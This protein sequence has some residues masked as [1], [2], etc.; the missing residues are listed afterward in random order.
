MVSAGS[1]TAVD[2]TYTP[3][4]GGLHGGIYQDTVA[5]V[6]EAR[7]AYGN[8]VVRGPVAE[9]QV[10]ETVGGDA[11]VGRLG[12]FITVGYKGSLVRVSAQAGVADME[13]ALQ[14]LPT[15]GQ[16]TVST[17]SCRVNSGLQ[18]AVTQGN[19]LVTASALGTYAV[20]DWIRLADPVTGPVFTVLS[21]DPAHN[22]ILLSSPYFGP[23][24][25][26]ALYSQ[27][28]DGYQYIV[29]FD[30]NLGDLPAL[31]VT[32]DSL[33]EN[34]NVT[35]HAYV[36]ACDQYT[37]QLITTSASASSP[38]HLNGTFSLSMGGESTPDL[39]YDVSPTALASAL[40]AF[41]AVYAVTVT[42]SVS[43]S[44]GGAA[45][46]GYAW[47]VTYVATDV[48]PS[49]IV[50][51]GHLLRGVGARITVDAGYCPSTAQPGAGAVGQV[52]PACH[53]LHTLTHSHSHTHTHIFMQ[54]LTG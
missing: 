14:S 47:T 5:F 22:T 31:T 41:D 24:G 19:A 52:R 21:L 1:T 28:R 43:N 11:A 20:G 26:V 53:S 3:G 45:V 7:D 42:R 36:T 35:S 10:I 48:A 12:G 13:R 50:A 49:A 23:T 29:T 8:R 40:Q 18:G 32:S 39:P 37:T 6:I 30:A 54:T 17:A 9:V 34:N 16:V 25:T 44:V 4:S 38:T 51:D 2:S 46:G 15:L 33:Y 27:P